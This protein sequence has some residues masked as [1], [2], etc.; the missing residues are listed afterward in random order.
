MLTDE[1]HKYILDTSTSYFINSTDV[2]LELFLKLRGLVVSHEHQYY[3]FVLSKNVSDFMFKLDANFIMN[4]TPETDKEKFEKG[5]FGTMLGANVVLN[6]DFPD[7][8]ILA[9]GYNADFT[10]KK[11]KM[12]IVKDGLSEFSIYEKLLIEEIEKEIRVWSAFN[13]CEFKELQKNE[14]PVWSAEKMRGCRD[15]TYYPPEFTLL[16]RYQH[17]PLKEEVLKDLIEDLD[18]TLNRCKSLSPNTSANTYL[19]YRKPMIVRLDGAV[20]G[21]YYKG[22]LVNISVSLVYS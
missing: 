17:L 19:T 16:F 6:E 18:A 2:N 12:L 8:I 15:K 22:I 9:I 14:I 20:D 21:K 13:N 3:S 1:M 4:L 10:S 7:N 5:S 11:T